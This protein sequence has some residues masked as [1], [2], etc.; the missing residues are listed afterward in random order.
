MQTG[1]ADM[2]MG[3]IGINEER[4]K[5]EENWPAMQMTVVKIVCLG[6]PYFLAASVTLAS[7]SLYLSFSRSIS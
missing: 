1:K 2:A 6:F 4:Q 7:S 5:Q 3:A